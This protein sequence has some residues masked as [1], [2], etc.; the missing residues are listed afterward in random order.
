MQTILVP[1]DF[2][3]ASET[4]LVYANKLAL[5]LP[6]EIVLVHS[7][8]GA[9]LTPERR[10]ALL[11]RLEALAERL[12]YQHLTRQSGR[13]IHYHYHMAAASLTDSLEVLV[14]GYRAT[15][16]VTG[17]ALVD[18]ATATAAGNPVM[19]LPEHVSC[20]VLI[21]PPGR[22]ELASEVVVSG[23]FSRLDAHQLAPLTS[24]A[25]TAEAHF[26][27]VQ[28]HPP[29]STGLVPLKK[30][31]MAAR[32]AIPNA[33]VHL[34]PEED[35]LEDISELCAQ[36]SAQLLVLATMDGC[37]VRRFFNPHYTQTNAYHLRI[38]VL[39]LP[40]STVPTKACCNQCGLRQAA[41]SRLMARITNVTF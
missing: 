3:A 35:A 14:S 1:I 7:H 9:T 8:V 41:E 20:P 12:R 24:L 10:V 6:A 11:S 36:L 2:S 39:L 40:T 4:A 17:L 25:R 13:R 30:A 18:C 27:L 26:D 15:L 23:D 32:A 28:F 38:P 29:T 5:H 21:V 22:H 31:L 33:T 34:L 19:L 16:V 37:L